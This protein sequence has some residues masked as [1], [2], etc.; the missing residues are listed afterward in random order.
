MNHLKLDTDKAIVLL[1]K[2]KDKQEVTCVRKEKNVVKSH[3]LE[4]I[5]TERAYL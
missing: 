5:I 3:T 4:C 2:L 1:M